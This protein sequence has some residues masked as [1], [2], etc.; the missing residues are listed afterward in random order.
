[1]KK[2]KI[3][4]SVLVFIGIVFAVH[5][6]SA[7]SSFAYPQVST[8]AATT[9]LVSLPTGSS[10][11]LVTDSYSTGIPRL[12]S[13]AT[14]LTQLTSST[15]SSVLN[16]SV[17][18]SVDGVDYYTDNINSATTTSIQSLN[19]PTSYQM[20]GTG[21]NAISRSAFVIKTPVRYAKVTFTS[22]TAT[23]SIWATVAPQREASN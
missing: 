6:V 19:S 9:T 2:T 11:T 12:N 4:T 1:M 22:A 23:S 7:N 20:I 17:T 5:S 15:T 21:S 13:S 10:T 18:Y 14:I 16:I 3:I 8:S